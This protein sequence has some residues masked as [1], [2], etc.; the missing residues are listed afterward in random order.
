MSRKIFY[1]KT[2]VLLQLRVDNSLH[3]DYKNTA[4]E[5]IYNKLANENFLFGSSTALSSDGFDTTNS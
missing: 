1:L 5:L 2:M 4:P 3:R